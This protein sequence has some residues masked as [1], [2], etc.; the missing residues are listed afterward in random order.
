MI[1][2]PVHCSCDSQE[3]WQFIQDHIKWTPSRQEFNDNNNLECDQPVKL[4]GKNFIR[5]EPQDFCKYCPFSPIN[6]PSK[7]GKL[8]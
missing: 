1:D 5:L 2:N 8:K 4:R 6:M 7:R 3:L